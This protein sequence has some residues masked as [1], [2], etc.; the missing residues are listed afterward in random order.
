MCPYLQDT[1]A[2]VYMSSE[3]DVWQSTPKRRSL[4]SAALAKALAHEQRTA[5]NAT[6][7]DNPT[8]VRVWLQVLVFYTRN[9]SGLSTINNDDAHYQS[10][11]LQRHTSEDLSQPILSR[12]LDMLDIGHGSVSSLVIERVLL[13]WNV[14]SCYR[15]CSL[16]IECVL[17]L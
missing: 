4:L 14:S 1:F 8:A 6:A 15:M 9:T 5:D 17:L 2:A 11:V 3:R 10:T 16:T 12:L 7:E 13:L